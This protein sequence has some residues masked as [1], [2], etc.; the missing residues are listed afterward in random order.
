MNTLNKY[1]STKNKLVDNDELEQIINDTNDLQLDNTKSKKKNLDFYA[2]IIQKI[3]R[4]YIYRLKHLPV[5]LYIFQNYL[6]NKIVKL[7]NK[8]KDGRINSVLDEDEIID[9]LEE[10]YKN[11]INRPKE[12]NWFD[13]IIKDYYY[14]WIPV[15]IKTS[16]CSTS[17]NTGNLAMCVYSYT[18]EKLE[19]NLDKTYNNG[20][21]SKI[22]I[23]KFKN[24]K[25]NK[26][27]KKD[28]YFIVINKNNTQEIIINSVKGLLYLTPNINNLPFQVRWDKNKIFEYKKISKSVKQFVDCLKK[29]NPSWSEIFLSK[30]RNI[31]I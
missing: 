5:I 21:M 16:K 31:N 25:Y 22:L 28:Y 19:L 26:E 27:N 17:D 24:K 10:K 14:G 18:N 6:K 30:I 3:Y 13:I 12:R 1:I 2:I 7:H 23:E 4:G 29:P 9:L 20:E 8:L 15:N 11:Y